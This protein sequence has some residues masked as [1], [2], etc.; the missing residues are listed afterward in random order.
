[1]WF[2]HGSKTVFL[3]EL[4][5]AKEALPHILGQGVELLDHAMVEHFNS[6]SHD[7]ERIS[8]LRYVQLTLNPV[9]SQI[10]SR[11]GRRSMLPR[12]LPRLQERCSHYGSPWP[13]PVSGTSAVATSTPP[14]R[15]KEAL[16]LRGPD[17]NASR[18]RTENDIAR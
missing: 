14:R 15:S 6:P 18:P 9:R 4:R 16:P 12:S 5:N 1:M 11:V 10:A 3:D 13:S 7:V 17:G 2:T 8:K